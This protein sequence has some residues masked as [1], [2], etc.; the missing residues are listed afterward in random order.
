MCRTGRRKAVTFAMRVLPFKLRNSH[1]LHWNLNE[2]MIRQLPILLIS[3]A[4]AS[5]AAAQVPSRLANPWAP[6]P[7]PASVFQPDAILPWY[8]GVFV[9]IGNDIA[10]LSDPPINEIRVQ[11]YTGFSLVP[12]NY[13]P[14]VGEV[15]YTHLIL[16]HPGNPC[17]GS[18]VA[19]ELLLPAGIAPAN[20]ADNPAFCFAVSGI[21]NQLI[22]LGND[23]GYGCPQTY[24]QGL[25][26]RAVIPPHG[27]VGGSGAWGMARGFWIELLIPLQASQPQ[28]GNNSIAWRVNPD[29]GVVGYPA[30]PVL[31]NNDVIFRSA[32]E[33]NQLTLDVCGIT[34]KP[35]GC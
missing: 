17:A 33:D 5:I 8:N 11:G 28:S 12:P 34:P 10:C 18:A 21:S 7:D 30:V 24:A 19:I 27:G 15:F 4:C 26:G 9:N 25:Q 13:T 29:I 16:S 6:G 20:S 2:I 31:V 35:G 3:I 32:M 14:A 1:G 23:A 22:N